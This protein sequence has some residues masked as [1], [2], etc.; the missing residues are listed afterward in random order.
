[1]ADEVFIDDL[2]DPDGT[3]PIAYN[4]DEE[5]QRHILSVLLVDRQF[6]LH[7]LDLIRSNY[8]TNKAHRQI[9]SILFD[10]FNKYRLL[11]KRDFIV[12]EIKNLISDEKSLTFYLGEINTLF[13][14]FESK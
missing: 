7:S 6:L 4:W 11:P 13:D 12:Q 3:E 14:Y 9:C 5:F 10:F 1:M 2:I 8:F